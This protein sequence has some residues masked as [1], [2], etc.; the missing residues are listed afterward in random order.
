VRRDNIV[1]KSD[2]GQLVVRGSCLSLIGSC[3]SSTYKLSDTH[4]NKYVEKLYQ[5]YI[6]LSIETFVQ[7]KKA[8]RGS[9]QEK[10]SSGELQ[11]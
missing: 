3:L 10:K 8:K 9:S 6:K 4:E 11:A 2:T 5:T 7:F 1:V